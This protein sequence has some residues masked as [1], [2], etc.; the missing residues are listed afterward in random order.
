MADSDTETGCK[1]LWEACGTWN[2][3]FRGEAYNRHVQAICSDAAGG[4]MG[5]AGLQDA[6]LQDEQTGVSGQRVGIGPSLSVE[7]D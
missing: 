2:H 7:S 3:S 1:V 5:S 4:G 6:R